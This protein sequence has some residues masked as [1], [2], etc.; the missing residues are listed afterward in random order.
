MPRYGLEVIE[1]TPRKL[2]VAAAEYAKVATQITSQKM[3]HTFSVSR[4]PLS[5]RAMREVLI[6][7]PSFFKTR[8]MQISLSDTV[9]ASR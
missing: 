9:P 7:F 5:P 8:R 4:V 1:T 6:K 3:S 2:V